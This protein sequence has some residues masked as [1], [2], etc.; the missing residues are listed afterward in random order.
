MECHPGPSVQE[1]HK[2]VI[3]KLIRTLRRFFAPEAAQEIWAFFKPKLLTLH[4]DFQEASPCS[5]TGEVVSCNQD[6][7]KHK[8]VSLP[9]LDQPLEHLKHLENGD[10][11]T[12]GLFF[13]TP[14]SAVWCARRAVLAK[15]SSL[16]R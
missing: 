4:L 8:N 13:T 11:I 1:N 12:S 14:E 6:M 2:E 3:L 5:V 16:L 10:R 9:G 15:V 7:N